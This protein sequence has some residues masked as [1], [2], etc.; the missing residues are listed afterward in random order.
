MRLEHLSTEPRRPGSPPFEAYRRNVTSQDGEDGILA[1]LFE[2]LG[3]TNKTCIE[4]G[5]ADGKWLS[6]T[7]SLIRNGDWDGILIEGQESSFRELERSYAGLSRVRLFNRYVDL[8]ANSLDR[9]LKEA[10]CPA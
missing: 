9:I 7:W 5:A 4:F 6:N 10:E 2:L 8:A 3:T 1:R